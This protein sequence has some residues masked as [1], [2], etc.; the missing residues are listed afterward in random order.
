[1]TRVAPVMPERPRP[2]ALSRAFAENFAMA[3]T[4]PK[5]EHPG[6]PEASRPV[7]ASF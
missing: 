7:L 4:N 5:E 2:H 1:M 6:K 3:Q